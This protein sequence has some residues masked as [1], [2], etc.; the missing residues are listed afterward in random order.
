VFRLSRIGGCSLGLRKTL[1]ILELSTTKGA[2]GYPRAPFV[3]ASMSFSLRGVV[4]TKGI[5]TYLT[6]LSS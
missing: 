2:R 1:L 4:T 3:Y 5:P 6:I